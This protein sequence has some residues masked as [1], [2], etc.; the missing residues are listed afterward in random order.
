MVALIA[1]SL[2]VVSKVEIAGMVEHLGDILDEILANLIVLPSG[3]HAM[4]VLEPRIVAGGEV[5]LRNHLESHSAKADDF[6]AELLDAPGS[7]HRKLG[8]AGVLDYLRKI[9]DDLVAAGLRESCGD[10]APG[11]L[12][13][14]HVVRTAAREPLLGHGRILR[15]KRHIPPR[16]HSEMREI[17][18]DKLG[19]R[20]L[21]RFGHGGTPAERNRTGGR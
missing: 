19:F 1:G 2:L 4:V 6:L 3:H 14:P 7:L 16:I 9:D 20:I 17:R 10:A 5:E 11:R 15:L 8:M 18:P 21:D 13:E 12:V